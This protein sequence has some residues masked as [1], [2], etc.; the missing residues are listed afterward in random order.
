M[1]QADGLQDIGEEA[2]EENADNNPQEDSRP[3]EEET[4]IHYTGLAFLRSPRRPLRC[5]IH[6]LHFRILRVLMFIRP[7]EMGVVWRLTKD[8]P[9]SLNHH[10]S[11]E[12]SRSSVSTYMRSIL[13]PLTYRDGE[14]PSSISDFGD[15]ERAGIRSC[16]TLCANPCSNPSL[17]SSRVATCARFARWKPGGRPPSLIEGWDPVKHEYAATVAGGCW[18]WWGRMRLSPD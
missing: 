16:P 4:Q 6:H 17:R 15:S 13:G 2:E 12:S 11:R 14:H 8:L 18:C 7:W 5:L 9:P 1:N 10:R 3:Q